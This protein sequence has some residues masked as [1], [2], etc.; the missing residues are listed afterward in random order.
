LGF[1]SYN[2][3]TREEKILAGLSRDMRY[4]EI[5]PSFSPVVPRRDGWKAWTVDHLSREG[6]LAKYHG[7]SRV[8]VTRIEDV[9]FVWAGGPLDCAVPGALHGSFDACIASHAVEHIPDFVGFFVSLAKVPASGGIVSLAV[10]DKRFCFDWFRPHSTT[11]QIIEAHRRPTAHHRPEAIFD[12]FAYACTNDGHMSWGQ[13]QVGALGFTNSL[14]EAQNLFLRPP[15]DGYL[16]CHAWQ[17]TPSSFELI[18][19]ELAAMNLIDF[20][21]VRTFPT[22]GCEFLVH[23]QR[24]RAPS[25]IDL[26]TRRLRLLEKI[27]DELGHQADI[28][29]AS[30]RVSNSLQAG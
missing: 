21:I 14:L 12:H 27:V 2:M 20:E 25:A 24:G 18:A 15:S 30:R 23:L 6:L 9:D 11:G 7:D 17:F 8:D 22:V 5:G 13:G 4:L 29:R 26:Q 16:D 19:L 10:P 28:L 1:A 3:I